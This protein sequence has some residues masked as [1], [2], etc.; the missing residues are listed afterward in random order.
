MGS[1]HRDPGAVGAPLGAARPDR[2]RGVLVR[3]SALIALGA[4]AAAYA[5][6]L[7]DPVADAPAAEA[8]LGT[9]V[10]VAPVVGLAR[11]VSA[12]PAIALALGY[13]VE[14]A[15]E[16]H[17]PAATIPC[18]ASELLVRAIGRGSRP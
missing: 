14:A 5:S 1:D 3:L 6:V 11:L 13:D 7:G 12:A 8:V 10:A 16:L 15:L 9:M 17:D 18:T 2:R 4:S